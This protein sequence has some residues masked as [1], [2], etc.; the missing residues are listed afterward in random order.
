MVSVAMLLVRSFDRAQRIYQ[1]MVLRGYT[2]EFWTLD[3]FRMR[4]AD[5][6]ALIAMAAVVAAETALQCLGTSS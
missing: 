5:W 1:A 6:F 2:G 3:H 4:R